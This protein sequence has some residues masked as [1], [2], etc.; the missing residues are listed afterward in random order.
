MIKVL[1]R[2]L[3]WL[4]TPTLAF[5]FSDYWWLILIAGAA[6]VWKTW[7]THEEVYGASL[8]L[9]RIQAEQGISATAS[10]PAMARARKRRAAQG[11]MEQESEEGESEEE[12]LARQRFAEFSEHHH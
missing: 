2:I 3:L 4:G 8:A 6:A 12:F 1:E 11:A 5:V 9:Q 10:E 7:P